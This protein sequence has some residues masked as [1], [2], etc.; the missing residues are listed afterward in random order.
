MKILKFNISTVATFISQLDYIIGNYHYK[1]IKLSG[2]TT[3][4]QVE[5]I[6]NFLSKYVNI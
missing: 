5:L 2:F 3:L 6:Y 4:N 1:F